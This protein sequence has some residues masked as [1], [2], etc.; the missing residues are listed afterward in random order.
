MKSCKSTDKP[1]L[2]RAGVRVLNGRHIS[3]YDGISGERLF[4]PFHIQN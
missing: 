4:G 3:A 2:D 1:H